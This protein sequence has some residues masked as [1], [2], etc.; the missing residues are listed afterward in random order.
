[1]KSNK[2]RIGISCGDLN[3]IGL[4]VTFK[5]LADP[6]V[7]ERFVPIVY[8]SEQAVNTHLNKL[9]IGEL[10]IRFIK[11]PEDAHG[12][13]INVVKVWDEDVSIQFGKPDAEIGSY[14]HKSLTTATED[15]A[16]TKIDVLVTAPFDKKT[17]QS[18]SFNYQGHTEY[19]ADYANEEHPL[20]IL[21]HDGL[22]VA[23]VTGHQAL[24]EV[25]GSLKKENILQK[26]RVFSKSLTQDFGLHRPQI[27]LLG[28]NPHNGDDGLMGD[29]E[30]RIIE[31]AIR[32]ANDEGILAFGPFPAD[33]LFGS[34]G[35]NRFDG[36]LAMYH[37]Q[38]LAPFKALSFDEGVNFT[39]GL[40][41]VRTSPD[42]GV[43]YDI[44]GKGLA[45]ERSMRNAFFMACDILEKRKTHRELV[46]N[47]LETKK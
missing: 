30:Q 16:S 5:A 26:L 46:S 34:P 1:M 19:L 9:N 2:T 7:Y 23:L 40:P 43:A 11:K 29:E 22:R 31:P 10:P 20:M 27:A 41:I 39:A 25:A 32:D 17:V 38:G 21:A 42:H 14:A 37:D 8:A 12:Q 28:L 13:K 24:S 36:I 15:L 33:G 4:E 47:P 35:R 6:R 44:A 3:G 45:S 18:E